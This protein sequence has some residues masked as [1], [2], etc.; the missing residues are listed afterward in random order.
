MLKHSTVNSTLQWVHDDAGTGAACLYSLLLRTANW[1]HTWQCPLDVACII[2]MDSIL[3]TQQ[4]CVV[5]V[6]IEA[7]ARFGCMGLMPCQGLHMGS[8]SSWWLI[9]GHT[10]SVIYIWFISY[11]MV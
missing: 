6:E 8:G 1:L 3:C 2:Q 11:S 7:H 5:I 4:D 10:W 9:L